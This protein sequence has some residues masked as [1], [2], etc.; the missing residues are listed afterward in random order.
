[1]A[2]DDSEHTIA[3]GPRDNSPIV[4]NHLANGIVKGNTVGVLGMSHGQYQFTIVSGH[5]EPGSGGLTGLS[6]QQLIQN[7]LD[8]FQNQY[9]QP[10]Q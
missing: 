3:P 9:Q 4:N 1:M 5:L 2:S 8:N 7:A 10:P 6:D